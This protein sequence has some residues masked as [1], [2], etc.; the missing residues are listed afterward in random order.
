ME[1]TTVSP[2]LQLG[3]KRMFSGV[4]DERT[5]TLEPRMSGSRSGWVEMPSRLL[6]VEGS[7]AY[8]LKPTTASA[9]GRLSAFGGKS[10]C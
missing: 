4:K 10:G 9:S 6:I 3:T 5:I 1:Q 7:C 2:V 8:S